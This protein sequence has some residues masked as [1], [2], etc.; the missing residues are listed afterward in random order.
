MENKALSLNQPLLCNFMASCMVE[1]IRQV[2]SLNVTTFIHKPARLD[3]KLLEN[4]SEIGC[5]LKLKT[6][7]VSV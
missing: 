7:V 5:F 3:T 6:L 1:T 2:A 4:M